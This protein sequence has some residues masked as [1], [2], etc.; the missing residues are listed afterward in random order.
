M[1]VADIVEEAISSV[2]NAV[3]DG[4]LKIPSSASS[5]KVVDLNS[6]VSVSWLGGTQEVMGGRV[7]YTKERFVDY[8]ADLEKYFQS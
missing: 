8:V 6:E 7:M 1:L 4:L 3:D 5:G 2:L